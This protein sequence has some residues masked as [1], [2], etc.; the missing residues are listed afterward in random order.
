MLFIFLEIGLVS[1]KIALIKTKVLFALKYPVKTNNVSLFVKD[2][3]SLLLYL[4]CF[5]ISIQPNPNY[6]Y[7][8]LHTK[9]FIL[10]R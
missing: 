6:N 1:F 7:F 5:K 10:T 9:I 8:I 3:Y 2:F 4:I